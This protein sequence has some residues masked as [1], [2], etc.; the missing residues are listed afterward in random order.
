MFIPGIVAV[1]LGAWLLGSI[2]SAWIAVRI[3]RKEDIRNLGS[4]NVGATNT[5]RILGLGGAVPVFLFDFFKGF[6]PV[7]F[8]LSGVSEYVPPSL[9]LAI[10]AGTASFLG[11]LFPV[12]IGFRGGKGVATGA[13]VLTALY[14]P[15]FVACLAVFLPVILVSR[16]MSV[17]AIAAVISVPFWYAGL[18][19]SFG[20]NIDPIMLGFTIVVGVLVIVKHR[21]NLDNLRNGTEKPLFQYRGKEEHE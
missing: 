2:P 18:Q 17:A 16:R 20:K 12:F 15:L 10:G 6:L 7:W 5:F 3:S 14:P 1:I 21:K 11:H 13:G 8:V 19:M 4:G 9:L